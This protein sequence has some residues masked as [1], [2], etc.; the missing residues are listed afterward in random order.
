[1]WVGAFFAA[2]GPLAVRSIGA[3]MGG[4]VA[5]A[6]GA[7]TPHEEAEQARLRSTADWTEGVRASAERREPRFE[8]R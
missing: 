2:A 3:T 7:A 1:M 8:G 6:V 4:G 5:A